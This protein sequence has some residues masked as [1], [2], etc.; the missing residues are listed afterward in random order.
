MNVSSIIVRTTQEHLQEVIDSINSMDLC[1]VHFYDTEGKIVATIEGNSIN[2]QMERMKSIQS[3]PSVFS[4]N[5]S[6]SYCED[7][8]LSGLDQIQDSCSPVPEKLK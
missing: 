7:E 6:Y 2:D 4:V 1:D 8:L 3:M 5:L